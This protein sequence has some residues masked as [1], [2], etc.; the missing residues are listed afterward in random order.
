MFRRFAAFACVALAS[1]FPPALLAQT[2]TIG[3]TALTSTGLVGVGRVAA[4]HKDKFGETFGSL[5]GLALDLR[6]WRRGTDGSYTGTLYAQPDRGITRSGAA[7]NY[8]P[9]THRLDLAFSPAPNGAANQI[10]LGLTVADTTR[11]TEANGTLLTS[12]DPATTTAGLGTRTGFPVLPQASTG[13]LALDPEG[14][15]LYG[16]ALRTAGKHEE[17]TAA[18]LQAIESVKGAPTFRRPELAR[19]EAISRQELKVSHKP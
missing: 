12:L 17:A 1:F 14:L 6:T 11:L 10:Q 5:S 4:A 9:R 2:V 13:R 7:T 19:W 15:V 18:F 3:G 8:T 16:R